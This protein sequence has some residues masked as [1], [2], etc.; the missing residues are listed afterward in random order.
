MIAWCCGCLASNPR[1]TCVCIYIFI[2]AYIYTHMCIYIH[3][4]IHHGGSRMVLFAFTWV[5]VA[6]WA[7]CQHHASGLSM[8]PWYWYGLLWHAVG[9]C[10]FIGQTFMGCWPMN[11]QCSCSAFAGVWFSKHVGS[12]G[13]KPCCT[14]LHFGHGCFGFRCCWGFQCVMDGIIAHHGLTLAT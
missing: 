9:Q 2:Y 11:A 14:L 5:G 4:Y 12:M 13:C 3:T 6:C 1:A 7:R 8:Y 10:L